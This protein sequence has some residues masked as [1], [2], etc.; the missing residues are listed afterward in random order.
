L[1]TSAQRQLPGRGGLLGAGVVVGWISSLFGIGGGSLTVPFLSWCNIVMQRAVACSAA[2]GLPIAVFGSLTYMWRGY[3]A[4]ALPQWSTGFVY[5][6]AFLGVVLTSSLFAKVGASFA[7]RLSAPLL[8]RIFALFLL[9]IGG[10]LVA[11]SGVIL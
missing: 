8:R 6:P 3:G 2:C 4:D 9:L 10:K 1:S 11:G 7:H 5:W